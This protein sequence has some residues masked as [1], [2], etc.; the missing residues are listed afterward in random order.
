MSHSIIPSKT[1][2]DLCRI[3]ASPEKTTSNVIHLTE[4]YLQGDLMLFNE[5]EFLNTLD[6]APIF[7]KILLDISFYFL[8]VQEL[9]QRWCTRLQISSGLSQVE[10]LQRREI[11]GKFSLEECVIV[12]QYTPLLES[13]WALKEREILR[14]S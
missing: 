9:W 4:V 11:V 10:S 7:L 12:R 3:S 6:S 13:L 5:Q 2:G 1:C 14:I 8:Y